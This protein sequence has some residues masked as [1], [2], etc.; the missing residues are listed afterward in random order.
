MLP[1]PLVRSG[2]STRSGLLRASL[3]T[4]ALLVITGLVGGVLGCGRGGEPVRG[5]SARAAAEVD[6]SSPD[7]AWRG[8]QA[9]LS[10]GD[11]EGL[12]PY[13]TEV[14]YRRVV[15]DLAAWRALVVDPAAGP[16]VV[17]RIR[18]PDDPAAR[19]AAEA[20]LKAE[21]PRGTLRVYV[22]AD[23]RPPYAPL[24]AHDASRDA[25]DV[26]LPTSGGETRPARFVRTPDG[27]RIDRLGL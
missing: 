8:A 16:R 13:L 11:L 14:G 18:L 2:P 6:R 23:P 1:S 15:R 20:D 27:W 4:L 9:A 12:R 24:P 19:A 25:F 7:A 22:A 3:R 26:E 10:K 21:D 17:A 5:T